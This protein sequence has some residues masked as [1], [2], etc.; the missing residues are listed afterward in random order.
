MVC[1]H[2]CIHAIE[3]QVLAAAALFG[4]LKKGSKKPLRPNDSFRRRPSSTESRANSDS[5]SDVRDSGSGSGSVCAYVCLCV[6]VFVCL[7]MYVCAYMCVCVYVC[8][9]MCVCVCCVRACMC[10]C[11]VCAR[12]CAR[13]RMFARMQAACPVWSVE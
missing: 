6:C 13:V 3:H 9:C 4:T 2:T 5:A 10:L 7:F 8:M 12:A 11:I 1:L